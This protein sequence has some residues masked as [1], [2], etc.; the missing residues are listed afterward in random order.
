[1]H[2]S[3]LIHSS[4]DG[5]PA[6]FLVLA[7]VLQLMPQYMC[8]F[9]FWFLWCVCPAVGLLGRVA[10][11]Y[12]SLKE[13][14]FFS[15][16]AI[17]VCI[18]TNSVRG[19][20]FLHTLS[21]ICYLETFWWQSFWLAWDSTSF[22]VLICVYL[23]MSDVEYLFMYL[24]AIYMSS[25]E[26]FLFSSLA[27]FLIEFSHSVMSDSLRPHELQHTRPPCPSPTPGV[28]LNPCP[29]SWWCHPTISPSATPSPPVL[30]LS[31]QQGFFKW[32][33]SSHQLT[34]VLEFQ[35]Q[36]QSFQWKPGTDIL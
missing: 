23:I 28:H 36:H 31:Q 15:I 9:Q 29:L 5:L 25:L 1:M 16:V 3:C 10:V 6:C 33:S 18:P 30:N 35:L 24:L 13:S 12:P 32:L 17:L 27:H 14:P 19:L 11:L 34:K 2:H 7:I 8:L 26:T 4:A 21:S 22:M 20:P